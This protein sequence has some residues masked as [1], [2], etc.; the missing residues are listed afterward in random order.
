[1]QKS[2]PPY[3]FVPL[4]DAKIAFPCPEI[5]PHTSWQAGKHEVYT[6]RLTF[7]AKVGSPVHIGSGLYELSEE[8]GFA[9]GFV[10][11]GI[12]RVAGEPVIP[13]SSWKG[14]VRATYEACTKSC[15]RLVASSTRESYSTEWKK[16]K[17]PAFVVDKLVST[18]DMNDRGRV[19]VRLAPGMIQ[20]WESCGEVKKPDYLKR[21]CPA[22][23]LFGGLGYRGRVRFLDGH[24]TKPI[25]E[26]E[27]K[28]IKVDSANSPHLHRAGSPKAVR[29]DLVEVSDLQGR[30]FYRY[31]GESHQRREPIDYLPIGAVL[32]LA[33]E[34]E[35][36]LLGEIG[37]LLLSM[38]V[39]DGPRLRVGGGKPLGLGE[40]QVELIGA[41]LRSAEALGQYEVLQT[42]VPDRDAWVRKATAAFTAAPF[43]HLKGFDALRALWRERPEV[44]R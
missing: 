11:R 3:V 27:R 21:L 36:L 29:K 10:V 43:F 44:Q 17:L 31:G 32:T 15:L 28:T 18:Y 7:E 38:G 42:Q 37:G 2:E 5:L 9:A 39:A 25:V 8:V 19:S 12:S 14:A 24:V 33:V 1:M 40:L 26:Q 35:R 20:K 4:P 34:F 41:E 6:G 30:K 16:S 13:G 23:A 22:C